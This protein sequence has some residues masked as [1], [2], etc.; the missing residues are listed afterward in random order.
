MIINRLK[1]ITVMFPF[2]KNETRTNVLEQSSLTLLVLFFIAYSSSSYSHN[3]GYPY[4]SLGINPQMGDMTLERCRTSVWHIGGHD[5]SVGEYKQNCYY[6]HEVPNPE[7][8]ASGSFATANNN[9]S[10]TCPSNN[11]KNPINIATGNKYFALHDIIGLGVNP[12]TFSLFY[13]T[14]TKKSPWTSAYSQ[15]LVVGIDDIAAIRPDG[16]ILSFRMNATVNGLVYTSGQSQNPTRLEQLS[17][18]DFG[19]AYKLTLPDGTVEYYRGYDKKL[20]SIDYLNG[21]SHTLTYLTNGVFINRSSVFPSSNDS[22][23]IARTDNKVTGVVFGGVYFKYNYDTVNGIDRLTT[24][25]YSDD[26]TR[27]YLYENTTFPH[28]IT[29]ILDENGNRISSVQYDSVGRAISSE[30]GELNSGIE[31]SQIEYHEDGTRTVTNALGKQNIYH[32]TEFNGEYKM[33]QVEGQASE[34]CASANQAYTYDTNGFMASKTDWKGNVTSYIHNDRGLETSRTEAS[35]T[36]EAHTIS[37]EWHATFN[38]RTKL[39]EPERETVYVY[40]AEGRLTS[41]EVSPR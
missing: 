28:Y 37:T 12:L 34:N 21:I 1:G 17:T 14:N 31:R 4:G 16:Q 20:H 27:T 36:P 13:N 35:G 18:N 32:F 3:I 40:D 2:F 9:G 39:T 11:T 19:R 26:T 23:S 33:T 15:S 38:L 10:S 24:V 29:G 25:T 8:F 5:L 7:V 6:Y 22:L 41:T 30:M